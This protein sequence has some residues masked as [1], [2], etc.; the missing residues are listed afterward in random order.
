MV[1]QP[2]LVRR[3]DVET[4]LINAVAAWLPGQGWAAVA[5]ADDLAPGDTSDAVGIYRTGGVM[6][7][8]TIDNPTITID[9]KAGTRTRS[10]SLINAVSAFLHGLPGY[11][12]TPGIGVCTVAEF[13]GPAL[14]PTIDSPTRYT[15]TFTIELQTAVD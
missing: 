3:V 7:S 15:Q 11:D 13:G 5:V 1:G 6:S 14:L 9:T 2:N 10:S 12:L 8:M 4:L